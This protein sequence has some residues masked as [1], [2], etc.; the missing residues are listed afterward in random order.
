MY[1]GDLVKWTFAATS[2]TFNEKNFWYYA[3]LIKEE[4][5]PKNSWIILLETGELMHASE[6]EIEVINGN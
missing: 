5:L 2:N 6:E 3:L 4:I 1:P